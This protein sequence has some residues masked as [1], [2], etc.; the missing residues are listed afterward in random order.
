MADGKMPPCRLLLF[1]LQLLFNGFFESVRSAFF[2]EATVDE[3]R[4]RA[5]DPDI[6]GIGDVTIQ[7]G[8]DLRRFE[9]LVEQAQ[10]E[11]KCHGK[12]LYKLRG[13][14]LLVGE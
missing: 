9:I 11:A 12:I 5:S 10:I 4:R 14:F 13:E 1:S 3:N 8:C 6:S 7:L 2:K